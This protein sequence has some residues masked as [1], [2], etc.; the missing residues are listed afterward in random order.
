M[1]QA[2]RASVKWPPMK[3]DLW[4][5]QRLVRRYV[6]FVLRKTGG[7]K[8]VAAK[9]LDVDLSTIYRWLAR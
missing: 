4:T 3:G 5:L 6:H 9:I 1:A 8:V 7:N 2:R